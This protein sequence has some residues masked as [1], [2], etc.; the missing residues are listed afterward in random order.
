MAILKVD[1]LNKNFGKVKAVQGI[2]FEASEG[3][4]LSLLGPSG[5]GKTTTLRCIAGFENPDQGEIYLDNR[6]ITTIPPEKRGIGMIFQNYAL[7]PHM[8]V[9]ENLAFSLQIRKVPKNE[10]T[11]KVKKILNMVQLEGY[12]NRYPR[13]MSGGQQQ[14]IAM[15]R[16]LVFEP[17]IMLLDEP[18]SNLDAKLR[19][20]MRFQ[21][22]ELQKSLGITAVYVT[23]DQAEALVISDKIVILDQG[24]IVQSGSPKEIYANPKNKF[25][26][27]FIAVTSF[28]SGRIDSF[29]E[30]KKKVIVK[31]D[32][33]LVI[34]GFNN[35][36]DIGQK[37]SVAMRMNVIKFIQDENKSDKNR[38][39]IF[40]GKIIQSSYLGNIIDYKIKVGNWE[41]RTN[42]DAKYN[43]KVGEEVTFYLSPEDI[44]VTREE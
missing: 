32:D 17:E 21:F 13:Q 19:E 7:W 33:G 29:T 10:I 36:F 2:T 35:S 37:V 3:K 28:I 44:I 30:E 27:G 23:H 38:V 22:T 15:A 42:S 4:V 31:T 39:N 12:E 14:R 9:Y 43:F 40:K 26:A 8:T 16:A 24:K 1:G 25:V 11:K 18:L 5:C 41:V 6:K 34:H 20:E